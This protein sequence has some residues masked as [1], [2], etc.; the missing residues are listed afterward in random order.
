MQP[1]TSGTTQL[2]FLLAN[3]IGDVGAMREVITQSQME[4][5]VRRS[6]SHGLPGLRQQ[7][8]S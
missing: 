8:L 4:L 5:K 3:V 2:R 1:M 6:L 7:V